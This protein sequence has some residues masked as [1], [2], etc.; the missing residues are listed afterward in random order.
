MP[1]LFGLIVLNC[2]GIVVLDDETTG[3][4]LG[5]DAS[6]DADA[7]TDALDNGDA[8]TCDSTIEG[9][10]TCCEGLPCRGQCDKNLGCRCGAV[11]GGCPLPTVCCGSVCGAASFCK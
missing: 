3:T 5:A 2:G 7:S 4:H 11:I 8:Y 1:A 9:L 10:F 6:I